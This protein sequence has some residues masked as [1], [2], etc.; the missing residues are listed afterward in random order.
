MKLPSNE[1]P[2][3]KFLKHHVTKNM[4]EGDCDN[5]MK[6]VNNENCKPVN[7]FIVSKEKK[8]ITDICGTAGCTCSSNLRISNKPFEVIT[9]NRVSK[10]PPCKYMG[11]KSSKNIILACERNNPVHYAGSIVPRTSAEES[12]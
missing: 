12:V 6:K 1:D 3:Q 10:K 4:T 11:Q 7:T 8:A 2:R 9:C 5:A